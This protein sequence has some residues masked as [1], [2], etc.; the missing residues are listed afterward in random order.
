MTYTVNQWNTGFTAQLEVANTGTAALDGWTLGFTF[1]SG[2]QVTQY[3]SSEIVQSGAQ[4]TATNAPW[5]G[6]LAPGGAVQI[7]FNGA[8]SGTNTA[9]STFTLNGATCTVA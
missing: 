4:V 9:P 1:P 3:W 2:Q 7:G 6:Q 5:N 8:Y